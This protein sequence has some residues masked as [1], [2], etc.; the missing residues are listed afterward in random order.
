M[1]KILYISGAVLPSKYANSVHVMKMCQAL[2]KINTE[3]TLTARGSDNLDIY[4]FY[5]VKK[6]FKVIKTKHIKNSA[7]RFLKYNYLCFKLIKN[8]D[9]VVFLRYFYPLIWCILFKKKV[10]LEFHG[11][12]NSKIISFLISK[13][14]KSDKFIMAIFITEKLKEKYIEKFKI[15]V[16]KCIVLADCADLPDKII[17]NTNVKE[18]GYVG[19]LYEGRGVEMIIDIAKVLKDTNFHIIGGLEKDIEKYKSIS[20][21]N[22]KF[23]GFITQG[24]LSEVY[25]KFSIALAPYQNKVGI[26]KLGVD[27]SKWMSPMKAFEY[28]SYKK[29]II[30]SNL[31]VL[32]E[33]GEDKFH[34]LYV[35]PDDPN[36]WIE[37]IV[38]LQNDKD[39]LNKL[40]NHS[41]EHFLRN[42]TWDG[43]AARII[44][45]TQN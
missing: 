44:E 34:F 40:R 3:V 37:A 31:P 18:V 35:A 28:M 45:F 16:K 15:P 13:V 41:Y 11:V 38:S 21:P 25:G 30:I 43:R 39:F 2:A 20:P 26:G 7:L 5:N 9:G 36:E 29:A 23:Y 4:K 17:E 24:E 27:T 8:H 10:I 6:N 42:F 14:F 1:N 33:I 19:H 32:K 12:T 22:M